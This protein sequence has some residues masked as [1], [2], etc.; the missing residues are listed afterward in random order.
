MCIN[1]QSS[2]VPLWKNVLF[3]L[4][5]ILNVAFC[6]LSFFVHILRRNERR[7]HGWKQLD[8]RLAYRLQRSEN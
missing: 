7:G 1:L 6:S 2:K 3:G 4:Q 5:L 8:T